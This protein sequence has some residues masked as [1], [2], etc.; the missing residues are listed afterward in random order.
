[1]RVLLERPNSHQQ[2]NKQG[3]LFHIYYNN[4]IRDDC[5]VEDIWICVYFI[6]P[7]PHTLLI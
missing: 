6:S 2:T 1:M 3:K 7:P 5:L 4:N